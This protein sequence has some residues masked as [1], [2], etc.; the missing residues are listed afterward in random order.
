MRNLEITQTITDRSSQVVESYLKDIAKVDLINVEEE[1]LLARKIKQG[2]KA[3][4]ERLVK[5]NLRFVVSVAK[6]YQHQ[7]LPLAD[8]ISEGNTGLIMA[9]H[10]FDESKGFKFISFA[11]WYIR[12]AIMDAISQQTRTVRLPD[13]HI[14]MLTKM[15]KY[16]STLEQKL[17]RD[18]RAE[19]LAESMQVP[20]YKVKDSVMHSGRTVSMDMPVGGEDSDFTLSDRLTDWEEADFCEIDTKSRSYYVEKLMSQL[21]QK[22][23]AVIELSFGLKGDYSLTPIDIA[24][25]F[26]ISSERVRQ[27]KNSGMSKLAELASRKMALFF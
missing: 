17:Q 27:L 6:K 22:E 3:A 1:V 13:N 26:G 4:M 23:R 16:E 24:L 25:N 18:P 9:A 8:L 12:Q 5:A 2:D 10:R 15:R 19:E 14:N 21:S 20:A 7:G 11:V